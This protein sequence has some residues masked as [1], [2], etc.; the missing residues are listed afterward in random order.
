MKQ[1]SDAAA[2][3]AGCAKS[4]HHLFFGDGRKIQMSPAAL[5][6]KMSDKIVR[7]ETLHH[8]DDRAFDFVVEARQQRIGIPL[9]ERFSRALGLRI[10][11]LERIVDDEEIAATTG[12]SAADGGREARPSGGG[13]DLGLRVL[14]RANAGCREYAP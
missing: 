11:R 14:C 10:L 5:F 1:I 12:Q 2:M 4:N 9:L 7:M 13:H 8:D 6:E 3:S